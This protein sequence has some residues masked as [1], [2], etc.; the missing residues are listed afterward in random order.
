MK[1]I[2]DVPWCIRWHIIRHW[3]KMPCIAF[4]LWGLVSTHLCKPQACTICL[5]CHSGLSVPYRVKCRIILGGGGG[6]VLFEIDK[7]RENVFVI[8]HFRLIWGARLERWSEHVWPLGHPLRR[9]EAFRRATR[10]LALFIKHQGCRLRLWHLC[11]DRWP[12]N[13]CN[14]ETMV[15]M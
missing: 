15:R 14:Q 1:M 10:K 7:A 9:W 5:S 8:K 3:F 2:L 4:D 11:G 13:Y 12:D 6:G